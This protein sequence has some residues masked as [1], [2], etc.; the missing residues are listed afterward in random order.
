MEED[1]TNEG[2]LPLV[3]PPTLMAPAERGV[4]QTMARD[5]AR[6]G[7]D[8][9]APSLLGVA[10]TCASAGCRLPAP[11]PSGNDLP[12]ERERLDPEHKSSAYKCAG[13]TETKARCPNLESSEVRMPA[14]SGKLKRD[15]QH[16]G[17]P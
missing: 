14:T 6:L 13:S 5:K 16:V 12:G 9:R 2:R 7:S 4:N 3:T 15:T 11:L 1:F 10:A 8:E 17:H